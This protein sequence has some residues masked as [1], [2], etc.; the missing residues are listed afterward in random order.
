MTE[1]FSLALSLLLQVFTLPQSA[2]ELEIPSGLLTCALCIYRRRGRLGLE[3][4]RADAPEFGRR[5]IISILIV[6]RAR[7]L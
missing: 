1:R 2:L 4:G 3:S 7:L 5:G 6:A